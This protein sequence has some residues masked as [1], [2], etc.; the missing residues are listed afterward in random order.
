MMKNVL[1]LFHTI[2]IGVPILNIVENGVKYCMITALQFEIMIIAILASVTCCLPGLFLVLRG[3]AMMSDAISHAILLGIVLM[4]LLIA[5]LDSPLLIIGASLAGVLTVV[6][7]EMIIRSKRLKKDAA[8]GLVFPLFFSVGVILVSQYARNVHLDVDMVLLG[9]LAFAPFNRLIVGGFDCGPSALWV[10]STALFVNLAFIVIF[11]KE[12]LITTFDATLATMTGF[13]PLF[14][15]YALMVLTSI[16]TV[17]TFDA[18]GSIMVVAL[19]ITPPATA[20]LLTKRVANMICLSV[21]LAVLAAIGGY[22][23]A[24]YADVSI[25]GSIASMTGVFFVLALIVSRGTVLS[26]KA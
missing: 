16:T 15:Y 7:T 11:Y 25:A 17:A 13:S 10:I 1:D 14:F 9:E 23:A 2:F 26:Q 8:I 24:S 3:V 18:V 12:L 6:C 21:V 4:F 5:R 19:M 20:Y 22:A